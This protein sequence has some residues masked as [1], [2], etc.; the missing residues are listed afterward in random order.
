MWQKN[1]SKI[2]F[3]HPRLKIF[4]DDVILPDGSSTK[5]LRFAKTHNSVT[6][7][8]QR[9]DQKILLLSEYSYPPNKW[10]LEFPGGLINTKE[11]P[12]SGANR[13]LMEEGKYYAHRLK[14][15]GKYFIN[16]RRS[17]AKMYVFYATDL[18]PKNL[19]QDHEESFKPEW[20]SAKN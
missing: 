17:N 2:I 5:Y 3:K 20:R 15:I 1:K 16:N 14:L 13:E 8:C 7:I 4:E 18:E 9:N 12:A 10:L 19:P 6:V 11:K